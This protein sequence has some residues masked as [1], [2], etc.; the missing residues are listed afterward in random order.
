MAE[1]YSFNAFRMRVTSFLWPRALFIYCYYNDPKF[2]IRHWAVPYPQVSLD[3]GM[4]DSEIN[5][6]IRVRK[7]R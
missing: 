6:A 2:Y 7:S 4:G 1:A 3:P 5:F